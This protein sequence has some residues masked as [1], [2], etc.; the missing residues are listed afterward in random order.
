MALATALSAQTRIP[1]RAV[2]NAASFAR[3][4]APQGALARGSIFTIFGQ[5]I[6]P[7][8]PSS[9][10]EFPLA[11]TLSGVEITVT[12][13]ETSVKAIPL[14]VSA[15]QIN[16]ILPSNAPLGHASL[17]V[18]NAGRRSN[19][20]P[21]EIGASQ[22]GVFTALGTGYGPGIAQNFESQTVQPINA[23]AVPASRGQVLTIWATGLGAVT[24]P[25]NDAPVPGNLDVDLRAWVGGVPVSPADLLYYGRSPCCAGVDQIILRVPSEAPLSCHAPLELQVGQG[26]PSNT[27]TL[28]IA[29]EGERCPDLQAIPDGAAPARVGV[30]TLA[31]AQ[32]ADS[33]DRSAPASYS[34]EVGGARFRS[35]PANLFDFDPLATVPP[36]GSCLAYNFAGNLSAFGDRS[37]G[38]GLDPG[39]EIRSHG[40]RGLL[41]WPSLSVQG[42]D[43]Y[44]LL[45][46]DAGGGGFLS[47]LLGSYLLPDV[48]QLAAD[49]GE[50][51]P[52]FTVEAAVPAELAWTNRAAVA[53]VDRAADLEIT[54]AAP[55]Q[56]ATAVLIGGA[57]YDSPSDSTS[58]FLCA[59]D[60]AAAR[61]VVPRRTLASIAPSRPEPRQ[62]TGWIYVGALAGN[63]PLAIEG[64][65]AAA[66]H[67]L[68]GQ[69]KTVVWR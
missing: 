12:Q 29:A 39:P 54:W 5:N 60:P 34:V 62:S 3:P 61:F 68:A 14:F 52:A 25:D 20:A 18:Q 8:D 48:Y 64:L 58:L 45:G 69:A 55:D 56:A 47:L 28:A 21:V 10:S 33:V 2:V 31:Q 37:G 4:G 27:V 38:A 41:R 35:R 11:Q 32:V 19:P 44:R 51:I 59:A 63:Q 67:A 15:G 50:D 43:F 26:A 53:S 24:F 23:P 42:W 16:A 46:G 57:N 30:I 13:G 7:A 6:G 22:L 36:A 17:M 1:P 49:G 66:A 9:V 40:P 65:D